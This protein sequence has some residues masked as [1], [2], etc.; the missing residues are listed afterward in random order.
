M[1]FVVVG[2]VRE[3]PDAAWCRKLLF[4]NNINRFGLDGESVQAVRTPLPTA[5]ILVPVA[6]ML[7]LVAGT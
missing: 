2:G 7:V 6:G 1:E 3:L 4:I 5:G